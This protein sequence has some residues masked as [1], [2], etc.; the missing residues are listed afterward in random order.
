MISNDNNNNNDRRGSFFD[1]D[2][3]LMCSAYSLADNL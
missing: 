3:W 2:S 1:L